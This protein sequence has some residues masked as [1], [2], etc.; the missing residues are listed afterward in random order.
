[1][2]IK[3]P[4]LLALSLSI[5]TL[6]AGIS[7]AADSPQSSPRQYPQQL[8]PGIPAD[9][10][11]NVDKRH[12]ANFAIKFKDEVS[13]L[14]TVGMFV[15]PG[16]TVDLETLFERRAANYRLYFSAGKATQT[17]R[18][19][20]QWQA[21]TQ[22][23]LVKIIVSEEPLD[24]TRYGEDHVINTF[25]MV[26]HTAVKKGVLEGYRIGQYPKKPLRGNRKYLPPTGFIRV[27]KE[28]ENTLISPHFRLKQFLCKQADG[29]P[30][31]VVLQERLLLKL[32][33]IIDK[34]KAE[35]FPVDTLHIMSGYRTP[36]YNKKIGNVQ[37]SR[38][39]WGGAADIFIDVKPRNGRM[40]DL[41]KDGNITLADARVMY[42]WVIALSKNQWYAP[43]IGGMGLYDANTR[44]GPF[45]HVDVRGSLAR[46]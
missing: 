37:Y 34:A 27:T 40:D 43:F 9:W 26:P 31:F 35:G 3:L 33:R 38:H 4:T 2:M 45:I 15:M 41:N 10:D 12:V 17:N 24:D 16:Q 22:P 30:K 7:S 8:T 21:P 6:H 18:N 46:W 19:R 29:Y 20:W 28:N 42:Q 36:F 1:M 39:Q 44:R 25:V 14:H 13:P 5:A 11:K 23:G 32:E